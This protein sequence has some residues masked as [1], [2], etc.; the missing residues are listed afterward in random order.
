M[1]SSLKMVFDISFI[2][3]RSQN[4]DKGMIYKSNFHKAAK[5]E[6]I[7]FRS[8][9]EKSFSSFAKGVNRIGMPG[10]IHL[11]PLRLFRNICHKTINHP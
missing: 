8:L 7:L 6:V 5:K 2:S 3:F 9:R 11:F 10:N 4:P 1:Q